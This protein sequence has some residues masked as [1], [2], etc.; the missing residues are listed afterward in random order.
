MVKAM[1]EQKKL[2]ER[3]NEIARATRYLQDLQWAKGKTSSY[4]DRE[5]EQTQQGISLLGSWSDAEYEANKKIVAEK[6]KLQKE[7]ME[8][9]QQQQQEKPQEIF[10]EP[11]NGKKK[12]EVVQK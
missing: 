8:A 9:M 1:K 4:Y 6:M 10:K 12:L 2:S 5:I 11:K 3:Q 7:K